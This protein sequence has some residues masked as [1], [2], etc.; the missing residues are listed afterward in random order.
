MDSNGDSNDQLLDLLTL[1]QR[2]S[3]ETLKSTTP[4][5]SSDDQPGIVNDNDDV[6]ARTESLDLLTPAQ[7]PVTE[8]N[9]VNIPTETSRDWDDDPFLSCDRSCD[10]NS[11]QN[12]GEER[13]MDDTDFRS[14]IEYMKLVKIYREHPKDKCVQMILREYASDETR[15]DQLRC[16]YFEHLK[17]V[18]DDFPFDHDIELKRPVFTKSGE[19][20]AT[21]LAK[22]IFNIIAVTEGRDFSLLREMLS[23][24]KTRRRQQSVVK[25]I[26]TP[27]KCQ[28]ATELSILK[29]TI[30]SIQASVLLLKQS[31]HASEMMRT[32]Q[33]N[34][35]KSTHLGIKS[36]I[37]ECTRTVHNVTSSAVQGMGN[38]SRQAMSRVTE[39]E[40]RIRFVEVY[41]ETKTN[42][43]PQ[44]P[45]LRPIST[46][47]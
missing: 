12:D 9:A 28:C 5:G 44:R 26:V 8:L 4:D 25:D 14:V 2:D 3:G 35:I 36:D 32:Q 47:I 41:L 46:E 40:D 22:D 38:I 42:T 17:Q 16:E 13:L 27:E 33:I 1:G 39:L 24:G 11:D 15:L 45:V 31:V 23:T 18:N 19:P 34:Q 43:T 20:V 37:V 7:L 30:A 29:D 21:R 10:G 6:R